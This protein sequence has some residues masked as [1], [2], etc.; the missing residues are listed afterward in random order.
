M[1]GRVGALIAL[2]AG[3]NHILTGREN[4]YVNGAVL[5]LKKREIDEKIEEIIDFADINEFI[6]SPVQSYSSGMQV[7]LGFA[8]AS[9]L[10]P[11]ILLTDEVLAVG[12]AG[13]RAKC[14]RKLADLR[15]R[16]T[17]IL[18][19]SHQMPDIQR[20]CTQCVWLLGGRIAHSG[21]TA[22]VV[23]E[24]LVWSDEQ[25]ESGR[26]ARKE[27]IQ[28][29]IS[30][31]RV[32]GVR[33]LA[34]DG[35]DCSV[36]KMGDELRVR[37]EYEVDPGI[38]GLNFSISIAANQEALYNGYASVDDGLTV[39]PSQSRG[40]VDLVF[41][42]LCLGAGAYWL[43]VSLSDRSFLGYYDWRWQ[44]AQ[45]TVVSHNRMWTRLAFPHFWQGSDFGPDRR[46]SAL[47]WP[48]PTNPGSSS[49]IE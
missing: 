1:R 30:G 37:L 24:Y 19:V 38:D 27:P 47:V 44:I 39:Y 42:G 34:S 7:R 41:P 12:D 6:D 33:T 16:G 45:F 21:E 2:G 13:F 28:S 8:V 22:K 31:A 46:F 17:T 25:S 43:N 18:L 26:S 9:S 32:L 3:F 40:H 48:R 20:V 15:T 35:Q 11:D 49:V 23:S 10:D 36:F 29:R 4:I 5:G 14:Y